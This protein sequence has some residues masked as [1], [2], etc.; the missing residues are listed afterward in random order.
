MKN[1]V[2]AT[3]IDGAIAVLRLN[4]PDQA[5]ALNRELFV[6][7]KETL[8]HLSGDDGVRVVIITGN[9]PKAFCA[10]IDLKERSG[11]K[12]E[13]TLVERETVIRPFYLTLGDFPKPTIAAINGP[14]LGGGAEL[15]LT[16]DI[17]LASEKAAFGQ[18]EVK[19]GMIP[20]CGACQ[21][22]R[23]IAG[24]AIAKEVIL[25]G[26]VLKAREAHQMGIFNRLLPEA[27]LMPAAL[28][29]ASE[30]A[31]NPPLAVKQAK[32]AIDS[33]ADISM[34]LDLDFEASKEC[35]LSGDTLDRTKTF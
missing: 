30:I 21:R 19:W 28:A 24:I 9:G 3:E 15:A 29:L 8:D 34:A 27:E 32:K 25:S 17:R 22:L 2:L 10:G 20:S 23:L 31:S 18:T 16:C 4:R 1:K 11:K 12:M 7:L 13:E 14:A 26:R 5:N 35:F 6:R 33:G